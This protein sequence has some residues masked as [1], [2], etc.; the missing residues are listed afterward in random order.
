MD[1]NIAI[2][3]EHNQIFVFIISIIANYTL[4]VFLVYKSTLMHTHILILF[5][6]FD[7]YLLVPPFSLFNL[8]K[9]LHVFDV[10]FS[11][12]NILYMLEKFLFLFRRVTHIHQYL[13]VVLKIPV[14]VIRDVLYKSWINVTQ[15][16]NP[17]FTHF[18]WN[19]N[20]LIYLIYVFCI[21]GFIIS[22]L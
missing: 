8:F 6:F 14:K 15:K 16:I 5:F 11:L 18:F 20:S 19:I 7:Y 12:L 22:C 2:P 21:H 10:V 13:I 9:N 1:R 3:T 4:S 17:V